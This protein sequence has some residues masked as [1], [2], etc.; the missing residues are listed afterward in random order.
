[1]KCLSRNQRSNAAPS[2]SGRLCGVAQRELE[3]RPILDRGA[4]VGQHR[5]EIAF[6]AAPQLRVDPID[7]HIDHRFAPLAARPAGQ[8]RDQRA[9][10]VAADG[11]YGVEQAVDVDPARGERGADRIHEEG[12]IVIDD[13]E[14]HAPMDAVAAGRFQRDC[15]LAGGAAGGQ[16]RHEGGGFGLVGGGEIIGLSGQCPFDQSRANSGRGLLPKS[17]SGQIGVR[18]PALR[19]D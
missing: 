14:P 2:P 11:Q 7:L 13:A 19:H 16:R 5:G 9:V 4:D 10:G 12:H 17:G 6:E 8:D 15:G 3:A 1:V 18:H